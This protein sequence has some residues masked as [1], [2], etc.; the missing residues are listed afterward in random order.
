[1]KV[2]KTTYFVGPY[3]ELFSNPGHQDSSE[4]KHNNTKDHLQEITFKLFPSNQENLFPTELIVGML[5][6]F[7]F[8]FYNSAS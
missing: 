7:Q 8:K 2:I 5:F 3:I 4:G 1:V 6:P